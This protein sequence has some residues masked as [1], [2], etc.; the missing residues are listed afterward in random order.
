MLQALQ[1]RSELLQPEI[2]DLYVFDV[3]FLP[4]WCSAC[5][6]WACR[7]FISLPSRTSNNW[8]AAGSAHSALKVPH[9]GDYQS[10][11]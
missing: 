6:C 5:C 1:M 7:M 11:S 9:T 3:H 2:T 8:L 4:P 10:L